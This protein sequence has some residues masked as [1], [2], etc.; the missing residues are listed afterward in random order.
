MYQFVRRVDGQGQDL[1][2]KAIQGLMRRPWVVS[3]RGYPGAGKTTLALEV[4]QRAVEKV[5][6]DAI[7]WIPA[8]TEKEGYVTSLKTICDTIG[9]VLGDRRVVATES[10]EE[11]HTLAIKNL[12]DLPRCLI[13]IDNTEVL[14]DTQ[15]QE[16]YH[17]VQ[18]VPMS[19]SVLLTSRERGRASEL[20]TDW[21]LCEMF[22]RPEGC[23][24][25]KKICAIFTKRPAASRQRCAWPL[26]S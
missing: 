6:F 7:I 8:R 26:A 16:I 23:R 20:E 17:F 3:I 22:V 21:P 11:K 24:P 25:A 9:Q 10:L 14:T 19:T 4:A 5:Y 2:E 15:H 18:Q 12:A 1:V 13:V